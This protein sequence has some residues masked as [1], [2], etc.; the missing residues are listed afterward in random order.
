[1]KTADEIVASHAI[2]NPT[3]A[4]LLR[5]ASR[6]LSEPEIPTA[7]IIASSGLQNPNDKTLAI[8][9]METVREASPHQ[10]PQ[11]AKSHQ[12]LR[13]AIA[14]LALI[15]VLASAVAVYE[16]AELAKTQSKLVAAVGENSNLAAKFS[17]QLSAAN[18]ASLSQLAEMHKSTLASLE[19]AGESGKGF[20][21]ATEKYLSQ[22]TELQ[23]EKIRLQSEIIVL[24]G[25][26]AAA[27]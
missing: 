15:A 6:A 17:S 2:V 13:V 21:E 19:A 8:A 9:L 25:N 27:K 7:S 22:I 20:R 16:S 23:A 3:D 18:A 26:A 5:V 14:A 10:V 11:P 24:K 4:A 1:M 12:A